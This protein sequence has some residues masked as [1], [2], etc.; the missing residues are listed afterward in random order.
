MYSQ[1][2]F[3]QGAEISLPENY[4]GTAFSEDNAQ[5]E[6]KIP[7]IESVK[8]EIKFSPTGD[9]DECQSASCEG[10]YEECIAKDKSKGAG[11]FGIDF[12]RSFGSLFSGGGFSSLLPKDFG[13]EEVLIIGIAL[14]LLFS[15]EHDIECALLLFA[16]IFIK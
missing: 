10:E 11:L 3:P 7:K 1:S 6:V 14:F 9:G 12:K 5:S 15:P 8:N 4:D 16:L 2:Y 13:V